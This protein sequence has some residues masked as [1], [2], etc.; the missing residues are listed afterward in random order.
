M[1]VKQRDA[2]DEIL[3][4][5]PTALTNLFHTYNPAAGTLDTRTNMGENV[6]D[7]TSDPARIICGILDEANSNPTQAQK[8]GQ[9]CTS[10]GSALGRSGALRPPRARRRPTWSTSTGPSAASWR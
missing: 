9:L 6:G 10:L 4:V 8:M 5:A 3:Q 2:L 7:L 1:L